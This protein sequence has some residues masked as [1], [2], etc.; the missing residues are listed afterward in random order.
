MGHHP[1]FY[2]PNSEK[3]VFSFTHGTVNSGLTAGDRIEIESSGFSHSNASINNNGQLVITAGEHLIVGAP[4]GLMTP[5]S[6]ATQTE[7]VFQWYDA[8]NS[9]Y[10]G[11]AGRRVMLR[12]QSNVNKQRAPLSCCYINS[13]IT[14]ELRVVSK[15]GNN[16]AG[17]DSYNLYYRG[18]SWGYIYSS[19]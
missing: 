9:Q 15:T 3:T 18:L 7:L 5:T 19:I 8:T 1:H 6:S 16:V 11:V 13:S 2:V 14:L 10:V 4:I 12:G 17:W